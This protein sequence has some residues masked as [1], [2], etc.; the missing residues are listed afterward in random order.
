MTPGRSPLPATLQTEA[1]DG[2]CSDIAMELPKRNCTVDLILS[3]VESLCKCVR[4][5][6]V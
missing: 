3:Y 6:L 2:M 1:E 5:S 4:E